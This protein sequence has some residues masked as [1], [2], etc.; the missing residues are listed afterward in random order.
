MSKDLHCTIVQL[1]RLAKARRKAIWSMV[2]QGAKPAQ[3]ARDLG[4]S[5]QRIGQIIQQAKEES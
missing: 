2:R 1:N 4:I 3:I 5:R